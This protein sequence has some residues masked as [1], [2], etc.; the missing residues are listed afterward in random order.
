MPREQDPIKVIETALSLGFSLS[1]AVQRAL[2]TTL[3]QFAAGRPFSVQSVSMCLSAYEGRVY[4]E[5]RDAIC[6]AL[7]IPREYL[8]RLIDSQRPSV[9]EKVG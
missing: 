4:G 1:E 9:A 3:T 2:G 8:D 5:I 6:D 7:D